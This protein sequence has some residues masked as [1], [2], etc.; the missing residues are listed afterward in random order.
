MQHIITNKILSNMSNDF[1]SSFDSGYNDTSNLTE[2]RTAST[3][4]TT[5]SSLVG[6]DDDSMMFFRSTVL[7]TSSLSPSF[8]ESNGFVSATPIKKESAIITN[9][10][11]KRFVDINTFISPLSKKFLKL[12]LL[13]SPSSSSN[14][15]LI[16]SPARVKKSNKLQKQIAFDFDDSPVKMDTPKNS[17]YFSKHVSEDDFIDL[18][19]KRYN[20]PSNPKLLIG[21]CVGVEN[22]DIIGELYKRSMTSIVKKIF[23]FLDISDFVNLFYVCKTW[24]RMIVNDTPINNQRMQFIRS[25]DLNKVS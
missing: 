24:N 14:K 20:L 19:I 6:K 8:D 16:R 1:K 17:S 13:K 25:Y 3:T 12:K 21:H 10:A 15:F 5:T 9:S 7:S 23:S 18:F 4:N 2:T 22:M 11:S